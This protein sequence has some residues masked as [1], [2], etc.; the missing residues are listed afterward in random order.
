M[1]TIIQPVLAMVGLTFMVWC[2][3]YFKRLRFIR[4]HSID[5]QSVATRALGAQSLAAV[6]APSDNLMNLFELPVLFY[7]LVVL[8]LITGEASQGFAIAA[9]AYVALRALHS[10]IHCTYNQVLHRF[11]VYAASSIM[12]WAMWAIFVVR[13]LS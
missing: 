1:T 7:L 5:P 8:L 10:L 11:T 2:Y 12:L 3:M 9:W 6:S 13:L 4:I